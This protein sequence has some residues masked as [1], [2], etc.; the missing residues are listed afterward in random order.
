M[1]LRP[2]HS[3]SAY[4]VFILLLAYELFYNV[5]LVSAVQQN[6]SAICIHI[7][8]PTWTFVPPPS[9]PPRPS[10]STILMITYQ[11]PQKRK[12]ITKWHT[13]STQSAVFSSLCCSGLNHFR[14][15]KF[16]ESLT[17]KWA[18]PF[19]STLWKWV[20]RYFYTRKKISDYEHKN[21]AKIEKHCSLCSIPYI[22]RLEWVIQEFIL[23]LASLPPGSLIPLT[24]L[25]LTPCIPF[26]SWQQSAGTREHHYWISPGRQWQILI[27]AG[28]DLD[29][30]HASQYSICEKQTFCF[31][32]MLCSLSCVQLFATH[33]LQP[34]RLFCP[35]NFPGKNTGVGCQ[36]LF[37]WILPTQGSNT[38]LLYV[39]PWQVNSLPLRHL[40][41]LAIIVL[42][43]VFHII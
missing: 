1:S 18:P 14:G 19:Y 12:F 8:P 3:K 5:V 39:L 32:I 22:I 11:S 41:I 23:F 37:Q 27:F 21:N 24:I 31:A 2:L 9:H 16:V 29:P 28:V 7:S 4:N 20:H 10:Q 40:G 6:E 35:W 43:K 38:H 34:T 13:F 17:Y 33:G 26:Q 42:Y 25:A 30:S 36:F 15:M